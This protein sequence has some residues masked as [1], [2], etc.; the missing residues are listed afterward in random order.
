MEKLLT[1]PQ[2][3]DLEGGGEPPALH[4]ACR[5]GCIEAARLLL[6]AN[7]DK[8]KTS[9]SGATPISFASVHGHTELVELLLEA[10]AD[11]DKAIGNG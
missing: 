5:R 2:D 6:E 1:R 9:A 3:P 10:N 7:A 11:K 4:C 8:E